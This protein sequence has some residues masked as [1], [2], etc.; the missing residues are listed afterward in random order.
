MQGVDCD[1]Q[2]WLSTCYIHF[3]KEK[4]FYFSMWPREKVEVSFWLKRV[5]FDMNGMNQNDYLDAVKEGV[6]L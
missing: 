1:H 2:V 3:L 6:P 4:C 5:T